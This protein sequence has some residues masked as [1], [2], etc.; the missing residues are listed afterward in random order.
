MF[1]VHTYTLASVRALCRRCPLY[2]THMFVHSAYGWEIDI[3]VRDTYVRSTYIYSGFCEGLCVVD[4]H[5]YETYMC[6][7]HTY[8]QAS[9]K[10]SAS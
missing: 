8:T 2:E 1:V 7:V 9:V 4:V 6:V 5:L 10:V 3:F